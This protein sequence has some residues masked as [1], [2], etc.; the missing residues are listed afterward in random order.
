M[1]SRQYRIALKRIKKT[2]VINVYADRSV[3]LGTEQE[4]GELRRRADYVQ[5]RHE[6]ADVLWF[7][8]GAEV[9]VERTWL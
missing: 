5:T 2:I 7:C 6:A 4:D 8:R 9:P 1:R 3:E